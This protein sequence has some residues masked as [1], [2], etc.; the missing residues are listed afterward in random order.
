MLTQKEITLDNQHYTKQAVIYM[1]T[2]IHPRGAALYFHGG[3]LL[4]G[5]KTDLPELHIAQL[6]QAGYA[7]IAYDYPLAPAAKL[8]LII[9]DVCASI[10]HYIDHSHDYVGGSL[11]YFLWGRSAGAYLCLMAAALSRLSSPPKGV[12]SYYGYGFLCDSWFKTPSAYYLSLPAV[13]E[14]CLAGCADELCALGELDTHYSKYVYA[15]QSGQWLSLIYEGREKLF[16]LEH[17]LRAVDSLPCPLFCAHSTGDTDVPYEEFLALCS[18]FNA[19]RFIAPCSTHD[20]DR[21]TDSELTSRLLAETID[22]LNRAL[23]A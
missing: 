23:G 19:R 5:L 9:D 17:S 12:L 13:D 14:S 6:T 2:D 20:F 16:Y 11:P 18:K 10:N 1:D 15:R 8:P 3:G 7:V 4:Y 21:D 22:F